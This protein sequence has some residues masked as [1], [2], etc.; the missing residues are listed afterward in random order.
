[1]LKGREGDRPTYE[2]LG[3]QTTLSPRTVAKI[4]SRDT[5]VD[6]RTLQIFFNAFGLPLSENDYAFVEAIKQHRRRTQ[7]AFNLFDLAEAAQASAIYGRQRELAQLEQW[8]KKDR[9]RLISISGIGG[10]GK[11]TLAAEFV[12]QSVAQTQ[13]LEPAIR[14]NPFLDSSAF[15]FVVW[16]SLRDAPSLRSVL[17]QVITFLGSHDSVECDPLEADDM[18]IHSL[19]QQFRQSRCLLVLDNWEALLKDGSRSGVY[20]QGY[21]DYGLLLQQ[22]AEIQ[23]QSCV[24]ITSRETPSEVTRGV[25]KKV[26]RVSDIAQTTQQMQL[27]GLSAIA[28]Q[29][30][31]QSL[32]CFSPTATDW[33]VCVERCGGSPLIL[34]AAAHFAHTYMSGDVSE[35]LSYLNQGSLLTDEIQSSL[36]AQFERMSTSEQQVMIWLAQHQSNHSLTTIQQA[37]VQTLSAQDLLLTIDSLQRRSLLSLLP[38]ANSRAQ[39]SVCPIMRTYLTDTLAA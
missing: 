27:S 4:V 16:K 1:M 12:A 5:G 23:H 3:A 10:I 22:I 13:E 25:I 20:R 36:K 8:I 30:L 15:E 14:N 38:E 31:L 11:T 6:L 18:T 37:F 24:M 29:R 9:C 34:R 17:T 28:G 39:F 33:Q 21:E 19:L 35:F 7:A 2:M 32:G 26:T